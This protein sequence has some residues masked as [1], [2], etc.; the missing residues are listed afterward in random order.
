MTTKK[1]NT[2]KTSGK[3]AAKPRTIKVV[4]ETEDGRTVETASTPATDT[5][6]IRVL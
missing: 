2:K 1:S 5:R 6:G 3:K 4:E